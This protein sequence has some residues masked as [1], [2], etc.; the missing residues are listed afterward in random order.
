MGL[1]KHCAIRSIIFSLMHLVIILAF[2]ADTF[3]VIPLITDDTGTQGKGSFQLELLGQ[4]GQDSEESITAKNADLL[5]TLTY[6]IIDSVDI[7][8]NVPYRAWRIE[9]PGSMV[10]GDGVTDLAIEA[11]WRFH[12]QGGLSFALKPGFTIPTGDEQEGLGAGRMRYYLIFIAT[13]KMKP[14]EFDMNLAYI[15]NENTVGER[16]NIWFASFDTQIEV[17]ENLKL[18]LD[19]GVATNPDSSSNTP[20]AFILGGLIW[21]LRENFDIGLGVKGG[22]T[23]PETDVAVRGGITWRF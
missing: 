22:L 5:T 20:L 1:R 11:K 4:Y 13:K 23:K 9:D 2:T 6:G 7:I 8:L 3:A 17:I 15:R 18:A 21:S 14:W 19:A 16:K 10:K 12:E